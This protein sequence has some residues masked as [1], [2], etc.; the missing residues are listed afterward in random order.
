M[1]ALQRLLVLI[2]KREPHPPTLPT[3]DKF[4]NLTG[5]PC[6]KARDLNQVTAAMRRRESSVTKVANQ[7]FLAVT[8]RRGQSFLAAKLMH[9]PIER[10]PTHPNTVVHEI[11]Q[12]EIARISARFGVP[13]PPNRSTDQDWCHK[14]F[15]QSLGCKQRFWRRIRSDRLLSRL[16]PHSLP[17][18][19]H[20]FL[21]D[22]LKRTERLVTLPTVRQLELFFTP[23]QQVAPMRKDNDDLGHRTPIALRDS[24]VAIRSFVQGVAKERFLPKASQVS[25]FE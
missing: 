8:D 9:Y 5:R 21:G 22:F 6:P 24:G 23:G 2:N 10:R 1:S 16:R 3:S 25:G 13:E 18:L 7:E 15:C 14:E 11:H 12:L 19:P 17:L 20:L 4:L